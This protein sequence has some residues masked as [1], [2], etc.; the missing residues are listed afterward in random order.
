M[1]ASDSVH[2]DWAYMCRNV[3]LERAWTKQSLIFN[4]SLKP[5]FHVLK[6]NGYNDIV[7]TRLHRDISHVRFTSQ[8]RRVL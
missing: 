3:L 5:D 8:R 2:F 7:Q 4:Q 1:S 6:I